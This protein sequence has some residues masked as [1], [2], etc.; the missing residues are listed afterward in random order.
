MSDSRY[1]DFGMESL[2]DRRM[3]AGDAFQIEA[4]PAAVLDRLEV[5][6]VTAGQDSVAEPNEGAILKSSCNVVYT[7]YTP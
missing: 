4:I 5:T 2:E 6:E 7:P 1:L 3:M